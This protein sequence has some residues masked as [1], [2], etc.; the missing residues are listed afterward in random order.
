VVV[1]DESGLYVPPGDAP[2]LRSAIERL[3]SNP[4]D[5]RRMGEAGRA[6]IEDEMS[7]D[8]YV[9]RLGKLVQNASKSR[10]G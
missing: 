5:A 9:R 1:Q 7:L 3:V 10:P 2:A 4:V 8:H 6:V